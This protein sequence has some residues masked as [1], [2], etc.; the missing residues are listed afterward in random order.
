MTTILGLQGDNFAVV[1]ADSRITSY[2]D[3]ES[4]YQ[5]NTLGGGSAKIATN[6]KYI[7]GAAGDMRAINILHHAFTPP[8]PTESLKGK[9]LDSF[10]TSKFVPAL[11]AGLEANGYSGT[12]KEGRVTHN[13]DI[14]VVVNASIYM[15]ESDYGWMSDS[16]GI[17]AIG[18][19][20]SYAL[21]ALEALLPKNKP[22]LQQAKTCLL[23]ALNIAGR[24]D[25][26]TGAPY[27][28]LSQER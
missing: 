20:S 15:I 27:V 14:V 23:K 22:T 7:I 24:Y 19:G 2:D 28:V 4:P 11:R 1:V 18:T 9:K 12:D 13:S 6:G 10:M 21:G 8:A 17:Y 5:V 26:M 25:V 16:R 3:S